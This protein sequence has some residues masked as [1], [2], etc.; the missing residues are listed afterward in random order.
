MV[1]ELTLNFCWLVIIEIT[2]T[3]CR[4]IIDQLVSS[5]LYTEWHF[6]PV[7]ANSYK[8]HELPKKLIIR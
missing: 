4:P 7:D 8:Q 6:K 2:L 3:I 1:T 5:K